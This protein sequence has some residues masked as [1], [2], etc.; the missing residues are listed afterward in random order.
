MQQNDVAYKQRVL[1]DGEEI[2][3]LVSIGEM[4]FEEGVI[5]VPETYKTRHI[6]NG[7]TNVP[8][9]EGVWKVGR[10]TTTWGYFKSWKENNEN[11]DVTIIDIDAHGTETGRTLY[12]DCECAKVTKPAY[13][14]ASPSYH[15]ASVT[16]VPYDYILL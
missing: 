10:D 5:D 15:Q 3:G 9:I 13:D 4:A 11:H 8:L 16:I 2:P 1:V 12:T 6:K 7:V 14:A